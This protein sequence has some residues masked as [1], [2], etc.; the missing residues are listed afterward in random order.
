MHG[1]RRPPSAP[2]PLVLAAGG[3]R[4][5]ARVSRPTSSSCLLFC[6]SHGHTVVGLHAPHPKKAVPESY[7]PSGP[8]RSYHLSPYHNVLGDTFPWDVPP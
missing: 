3:V 2:H 1:L 5:Q 6:I 8:F 4:L 7:A